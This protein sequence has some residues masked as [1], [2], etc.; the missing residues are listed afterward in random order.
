MA[1][2]ERAHRIDTTFGLPFAVPPSCHVNRGD[3]EL[4][5]SVLRILAGQR[6]GLNEYNRNL[7]DYQR[8]ELSGDD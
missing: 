5:D 1:A 8:N 4:A 6:E 7:L 3:Y 2:F